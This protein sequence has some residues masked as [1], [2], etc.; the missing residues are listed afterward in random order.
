MPA[1]TNLRCIVFAHGGILIHIVANEA[2]IW[3]KEWPAPYSRHAEAPA[4]CENPTLT[5]L[6]DN[7]GLIG[8]YS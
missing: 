8:W 2:R 1:E 3:I 4:A 7:A 5:P 6:I